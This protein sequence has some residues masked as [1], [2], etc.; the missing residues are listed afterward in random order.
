M[1]HALIEKPLYGT[2]PLLDQLSISQKI[3][4]VCSNHAP[5][6]AF[7]VGSKRWR[8]VQGCCNHW[9]CPRCG[10]MRARHEYG[11]IV[12][13]CR[14]LELSEELWFITI[15]CRG[16]EMTV[17]EA[18]RSYLLWTNR[19]LTSLRYDAGKRGI[20]WAYAQVTEWQKRGHPHSHILTTY[21][22]ADLIDGYKTSFLPVS[23]GGTLA[24][25]NPALRSAYLQ[26]RVIS[27]GLGSQYDISQVF[28]VEGASRYVA[29]YLFKDTMFDAQYPAKWR[30]VR[31][32]RSFPQLPEKPVTGL[33]LL[34]RQDWYT[35][36]R[37]AIVLDCVGKTSYD[38]A[39]YFLSGSD[40]LLYEKPE[41]ARTK[42]PMKPV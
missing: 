17:D 14:T 28:T 31:Y 21:Y 34:S 35:L 2:T 39:R 36:A 27:A 38:E 42:L 29:K 22:P 24:V 1:P 23:G 5:F 16:K 30:R 26:K 9:N 7:P 41:I 4:E 15:T 11:R 25:E 32:S 12:E 18:I 40:T 33:C 6:I 37:A 8:L 19:L 13:G 20:S 10:Q 3:A